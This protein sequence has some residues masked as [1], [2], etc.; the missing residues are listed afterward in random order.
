MERRGFLLRHFLY[1]AEHFTRPGEIEFATRLQLAQRR[2]HV[3]RP[4]D[5]GVHSR[6]SVG[7][8][9]GYKTLRREMITLI[10]FLLAENMED[11]RIAFQTR[12]VQLDS[13][14]QMG[15]SA[16]PAVGV[17]YC[18]AADYAMYVV[19]FRQQMLNQIA[20]VLPGNTSN[21]RAFSAHCFLPVCPTSLTARSRQIWWVM[22]AQAKIG[23]IRGYCYSLSAENCCRSGPAEIHSLL[24]SP[25]HSSR[26]PRYFYRTSNSRIAAP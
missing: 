4:I 2:Q 3:M 5:V 23:V 7:E 8:T 1:F 26:S 25:E 20:T 14:Q 22:N 24:S 17:F 19:S 12:G 13:I 10:I 6:E 21:K 11:A 15:N 18:D 16:K 9:L